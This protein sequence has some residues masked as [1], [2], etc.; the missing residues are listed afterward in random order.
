M[1]IKKIIYISLMND[2]EVIYALKL[3]EENNFEYLIYDDTNLIDKDNFFLLVNKG[4]NFRKY[5]TGIMFI[6]KKYD[7][8]K[9][10]VVEKEGK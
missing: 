3:N 8:D 6:H 4:Y 5:D 10:K 2:K 7:Y 9:E 1:R